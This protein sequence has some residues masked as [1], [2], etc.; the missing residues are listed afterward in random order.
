MIGTIPKR[1]GN[2][3]S[4][5]NDSS[6]KKLPEVII[7][8][9]PS[10]SVTPIKVKK[11]ENKISNTDAGDSALE[12][13][14][15]S[16]IMTKKG[17]TQDLF[18]A[19]DKYDNDDIAVN[20]I[21]KQSFADDPILEN[22]NKEDFS[23]RYQSSRAAAMV[24]K[25]RISSKG[26][27]DD[28]ADDTKGDIGEQNDQSQWVQC[29]GCL[30]WRKI[31]IN[32]DTDA[33][34]KDS[35][36]CGMNIWDLKHNSCDIPEES[37]DSV[38][39][40]NDNDHSAKK[41]SN[42]GRKKSGSNYQDDN[43]M[44]D[45]EQGDGVGRKRNMLKNNSGGKSPV[46]EK[47]DWVQCNKCEKWRKVPAHINVAELP[48]VWYCSLNKWAPL[49]AKCSA[50]EESEPIGDDDKTDKGN[51]GK[52]GPG[53]V[54]PFH[55]SV[56][57]LPDGLK[58]V[59]Q[60]VQCER[61]NCKKWRKLPGHV[62]MTQ[63]PEKWYCE[64]NKWDPDRASC[65][66]DETD[67]ESEQQP[68]SK[69][70]TQL[71]MNNS[72]GSGALS[73]RRIIFGHDGRIRTSFSEKNKN[74]YG[75]FSFA[76]THRPNEVNDYVDP[77]RR[78]SYWCSSVYNESSV[79][80]DNQL[81]SRIKKDK[82]V[83]KVSTDSDETKLIKRQKNDNNELEPTYLL[84]SI[85]RIHSIDNV[86]KYVSTTHIQR[87]KAIRCYNDLKIIDR[88]NIECKIVKSCMLS[89]ATKSIPIHNL[90][91]IISS[92]RFLDYK[93]EICRQNMEIESLKAAV[94]RLELV[95]EL[96]VVLNA[97]GEFMVQGV[98]TQSSSHI[99]QNLFESPFGLQGLP[100]KLRKSNSLINKIKVAHENHE[101]NEEINDSNETSNEVNMDSEKL[102][103]KSTP[104]ESV[105][106]DENF[107]ENVE[108]VVNNVP[109]N[110]AETSN[111]M[112]S[113]NEK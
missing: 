40:N 48:E 6:L 47:V 42:K 81:K 59:T 5:L 29:D 17:S 104:I 105:R 2:S 85:R 54:S 22:E 36:F 76:E 63:L 27:L 62:D 102:K 39:D 50:K 1:S 86:P 14:L 82:E 15:E 99:D 61:R 111:E 20:K 108:I 9:A 92:S 101:G 4:Q 83:S 75:L 13:D 16:D 77:T 65:D 107:D 103:N 109:T 51:K 93:E 3:E 55:M 110:A 87:C 56:A 73:Y 24:A 35:W 33:L 31:P 10:K 19:E 34:A 43:D 49:M 97:D 58:K 64:M 41:K 95:G 45:K 112:V 74:G 32:V 68:N 44:S 100:L 30:K 21:K 26:K 38:V 23:P 106:I 89:T 60:W 70:R 66:A 37:S 113:E 57:S 12:Q 46:V 71:I 78:I 90:L 11:D 7:D 80:S 52:R 98:S 79:K 18:N 25:T 88:T 96:E 67:S 8:D 53:I 28:K 72:K 91:K 84:D 94:R 69:T